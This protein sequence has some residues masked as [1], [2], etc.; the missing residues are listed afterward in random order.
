[1]II[2]ISGMSGS[3]KNTV[4]EKV[5]N[6][7][8]MRTVE[9][10]FK[11]YANDSGIDLMEFQKMARKNSNIDKD[12]DRRVVRDANKGNCVITT[13]LGP[14]TVK[15][16]KLRVWLDADEKTRANR[17]SKREKRSVSNALTHLRKRDRDNILRYKKLYGI[18]IRD[19]EIFDIVVNTENLL[20]DDIAK[21]II[22]AAKRMNRGV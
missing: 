13:W 18:D 15:K 1:M 11:D 7:L 9:Y 14:W 22:I 3:G 19:R 17:I 2:A 10:T 16:A 8:R 5:A 6:A 20:P 4:G 12:F 21:M